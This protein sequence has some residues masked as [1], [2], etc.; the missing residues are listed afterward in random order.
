[1]NTT[2]RDVLLLVAIVTA[3]CGAIYLDGL[4]KR[5]NQPKGPC[6]DQQGCARCDAHGT[7]DLCADCD[8]T[9]AK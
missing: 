2:L 1:M 4:R 7:D 6:L 3:F 9:V 8:R 5:R